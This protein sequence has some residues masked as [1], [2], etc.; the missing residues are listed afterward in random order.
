MV[1]NVKFFGGCVGS[2]GLLK[3]RRNE[4]D[5]G[6]ICLIRIADI[7]RASVRFT[8]VCTLSAHKRAKTRT[9]CA[10]SGSAR[11]L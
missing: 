2:A 8:K 9:Q 6:F 5:R 4:A 1:K 11:A 3:D 7:Q 10:K